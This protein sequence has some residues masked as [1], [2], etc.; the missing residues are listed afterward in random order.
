MSTQKKSSCNKPLPPVF[1]L[2]LQIVQSN[3]LNLKVSCL[4][5]NKLQHRA[6]NSTKALKLHLDFHCLYTEDS[7]MFVSLS[8]ILRLQLQ[9]KVDVPQIV[10][11][12]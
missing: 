1:Y 4:F 7:C 12:W 11:I 9:A 6:F 5:S 2:F 10:R 3:I 8:D